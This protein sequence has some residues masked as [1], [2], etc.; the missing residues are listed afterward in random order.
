M[1]NPASVG[2]QAIKNV[3]GTEVLARAPENF[4]HKTP[5]PA[6]TQALLAAKPVSLIETSGGAYSR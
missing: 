3:T 2:I 6:E 4:Q 1:T 5:L